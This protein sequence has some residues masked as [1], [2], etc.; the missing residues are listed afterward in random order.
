M[1]IQSREHFAHH[2]NCIFVA[3]L[4]TIK[5]VSNFF[6]IHHQGVHV[7]FIGILL[8]FRLNS[9]RC[10][11][12]R[13]ELLRLSF[14]IATHTANHTSYEHLCSSHHE[15]RVSGTLNQRI[16]C[17]TSCK[18]TT[19]TN[20]DTNQHVTL[21]RQFISLIND[22][23]FI[24]GEA[25]IFNSK[26][27][28]LEMIF[29]VIVNCFRSRIVL[30]VIRI[31]F[32]F[33]Q[34]AKTILNQT[35]HLS[36]IANRATRCFVDGINNILACCI[37]TSFF[38]FAQLGLIDIPTCNQLGIFLQ[39]FRQ[40]I[41]LLGVN[42]NKFDA[43][44]LDYRIA[45]PNSLFGTLNHGFVWINQPTSSIDFFLAR[46]IEE[47]KAHAFLRVFNPFNNGL[48]PAFEFFFVADCGP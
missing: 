43:F 21:N 11:N 2:L 6:S 20:G 4:A 8:A 38:F 46:C 33:K 30:S 42:V 48:T 3:E 22:L 32:I 23:A 37:T 27:L 35:H 9:K 40:F 29:N 14:L 45:S 41:L 1:E 17:E 39:I 13:F 28:Q 24:Q 10:I 25:R 26:A 44:I 7:G 47:V 31:H 5:S 16:L 18:A 34:A 19:E 12:V 36:R 15:L